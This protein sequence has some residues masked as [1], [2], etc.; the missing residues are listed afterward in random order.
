MPRSDTQF[1]VGNKCFKRERLTGRPAYWTDAK[2]E[3]VIDS[4][5]KWMVKDDSITMAGW[6]GEESITRDVIDHVKKKS[7]VFSRT[8]EIARQIVADRIAKKTGN[9]L[10]SAVCNLLLP[11][12]DGDVKDHQI[13]MIKARSN[14][15]ADAHVTTCDKL[16]EIFEK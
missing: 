4:L 6:R 7:A 8:Y 3:E 2:I 14:A 5:Q 12:Y 16:K 11:V 9:G 1:K 13:E 15:D 10:H